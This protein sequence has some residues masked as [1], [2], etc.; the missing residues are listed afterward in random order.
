MKKWLSIVGIMFS[1]FFTTIVF[2]NSNNVPEEVDYNIKFGN[3]VVE[4]PYP[5]F[6]HN[7]R[8]YIPLRGMCDKLRIPLIW[9]GNNREVNMNI[10]QKDIPVSDKTLLKEGGVLPDE[11]TALAVGK[12][13][14]E[15][16]IGK[17][18][19]YETDEK[20]YY[21]SVTYREDRNAWNIQQFFD[22]K[23]GRHWAASGIYL[24]NITL[25]KNTGE[26]M[27]INTYSSIKR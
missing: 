4:L 25:N 5:I 24:P 26:V 21:L 6:M 15:K 7:D 11:E 8:L 3:T 23:D 16:Y 18:L 22:Y 10:F 17:P 12:I 1:I 9:D 27:F 20:I 13:I 2:A 19:E 14:L